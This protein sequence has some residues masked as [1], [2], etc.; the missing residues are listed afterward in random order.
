MCSK[1]VQSGFVSLRAAVSGKGFSMTEQSQFHT[2]QKPPRL[3]MISSLTGLGHVSLTAA[4]PVVSVL[5]VQ[6]CPLPSSILSGH[7]AYPAVYKTDLTGQ[8]AEYLAV[9][10][11][12]DARFDGMYIGYLADAGQGVLLTEI[13]DR[14]Y[15]G[16]KNSPA[17]LLSGNRLLAPHARVLVDPVMADH[18]KP[19]SSVT[20][21]HIDSMKK[22]AALAD[23]LT[24]NLTEACLL[25]A[26]PYREDGWDIPSLTEL[27]RKLDP[28]SQKQI[29]I[30][31]VKTESYL[32]NFLWEHG[33]I[34]AVTYE[35]AGA[36]RPGTGDIFASILA[37]HMVLGHDLETAAKQATA[38]I[39]ACIADSEAAGILLREGVLLEPNLYRLMPPQTD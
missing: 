2:I 16:E 1:E 26:T 4:L 12:L 33:A 39:S 6:P 11:K 17:A 3:A 5:G 28:E 13:L 27:C 10:E 18:G 24:P 22:L 29:V 31:G 30:T 15:T 36:S 25:T 19:Y 8:M 20:K 35:N 21:A 37:S 34:A 38:F 14:K 7:L 23:I 9:W 32:C